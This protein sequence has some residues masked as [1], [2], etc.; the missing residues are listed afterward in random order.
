MTAWLQSLDAALFRFIN[1]SLS[2]PF[3][4]WLMPVLSG[5]KLFVPAVIVASALLIW[6]QKGR[7]AL[8]V[9]FIL[10]AVALGDPLII[11]SIKH[12]VARPRPFVP[13][14]EAISL[15]GRTSSFSLPSAHAANMAAAAMV[16]F[17]F[18]RGSWR[19]MVP[20]AAAVAFSR[21]YNGVHYV[22]D[23]LIG[24]VLGAGYA[25]VMVWALD[26][27]W[28][29]AGR[30]WF[31]L[32]WARLPSLYLTAGDAV[33]RHRRD[34]PRLSMR[35]RKDA[36]TRAD[37][38]AKRWAMRFTTRLLGGLRE[39]IAERQKARAVVE[40]LEQRELN[41]HWLRLGYVVVAVFFLARLAYIASPTIE[42]S[43]DEAYQWQWSKHPALA[44][45]SKP[46]GIAVAQWIGTHLWGDTAFGVRFLAPCVSALISVLLL[47]F[48]AREATAKLG[49]FVV[50]AATATPLLSVG[51]V[52][53][54]VDCL[55]VL[56]WTLAMLSGWQA[57][58]SGERGLQ[59]AETDSATSAFGHSVVG[60]PC[61]GMNAAL[62]PWL[63]TGLWLALGFLSKNTNAFQFA[64]FALFFALWKPAR[65]QLR[66]AGPW[67]ALGIA[68]L[69]VLPQL[70][71]NAQNGWAT[72]E[73]L[74]NRAGLTQ[75]WRFTPNYLVDFV[76]A[77]LALLNPAFLALILGG[78][79]T[80]LA[81]LRA[82]GF[83]PPPVGSSS[84]SSSEPQVRRPE[85]HPTDQGTGLRPNRWKFTVRM[86]GARK[87]LS[88]SRTADGDCK[89]PARGG[90]LP[91]FLL[92][93]GLPLFLGY[94]LY[95]LRARVQPNWIVPAVLPLLCLAALQANA[96]WRKGVRSVRVWFIAGLAL[97]LPL[98][99]LLHDTNLTGKLFGQTLPT[100]RDPLVRVRGWKAMAET[101][102][103]ERQ[104]VIAAEGKPVFLIGAHYGIT[105]LLSFYIPE[106]KAAVPRA[107]IVFYQSSEKPENQY[108]FWPGYASRKGHSALYVQQLKQGA[109]PEPPPARLAAEFARIEDLGARDIEHRGRVIHTVRLLLCRELK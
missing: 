66:T 59:A 109:Q 16:A 11:N 108:G 64:C 26:R 15:V 28:G 75:S 92:C 78:V 94:F 65:V 8:C 95:T 25:A 46:P 23:V 47:R 2:N 80:T 34:R 44:Y 3:F 54:T 91:T 71:W 67:L 77:E 50:L 49:L 99:V 36:P 5:N 40:G 107:P 53:M 98:V 42:L 104:R 102:E 61:C 17:L 101:V 30:K 76:V 4:D 52:L 1:Q 24:A 19:F 45:Y 21:V 7:G 93:M 85:P 31:P 86:E 81:Q 96:C 58:R 87:R 105:S 97:G 72:V 14:P 70:I 10:L 79:L 103:A 82:G 69:A 89:S 83:Q 38:L 60:Q 57:V 68:A 12:A 51:A 90:A 56:F 73:H 63:W 27:C 48:F 13:M 43:E 106:A 100:N 39:T 35:W 22:S 88:P 55:S 20:L 9:A 41:F 33:A 84:Q 6:R 32:W 74:H 37:A 62:R 18:F 29:W